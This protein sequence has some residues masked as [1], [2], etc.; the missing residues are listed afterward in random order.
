MLPTLSDLSLAAPPVGLTFAEMASFMKDSFFAF[1]VSD[2]MTR[3][4]LLSAQSG[5]H[6]FACAQC[7]VIGTLWSWGVD[8]N[9]Q[10]HRAPLEA[11]VRELMIRG[12]VEH[13]DSQGSGGAVL[14]W[15]VYKPGENGS[16]GIGVH[17]SPGAIRRSAFG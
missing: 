11:L 13:P 9:P 14:T 2:T 12:F 8:D 6:K 4:R 7:V 16:R 15:P 3:N 1:I 17:P 5:V 10:L